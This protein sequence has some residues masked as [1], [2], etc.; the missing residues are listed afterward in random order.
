MFQQPQDQGEAPRSRN[1]KTSADLFPDQCLHALCDSRW[2]LTAVLYLCEIPYAGGTFAKRFCQYVG[3]RHRVLDGKIDPDAT[4]RRHGVR[5]I[6]DAQQS[7]AI[8]PPQTIDS[9]SQELYPFPVTQFAHA[10]TQ[11]GR[12]LDNTRAELLNPFRL[13]FLCGSFRNSKTALP[14]VSAIEQYQRPSAIGVDKQIRI[15]GAFGQPHPQHIHRCANLFD[16]QTGT[17]P[18]RGV[19]TVCTNHQF[20]ADLHRTGW[21]VSANADDAAL[22]FDQPC[23][24]RLHFQMKRWIAA[25]LLGQEVQEFPL[26]H[27]RDEAALGPEV[28]HI[29]QN[30]LLAGDPCVGS[31]PL[32]MRTLEKLLQHAQLMHYLQS[33][34]MNGV[35][36]EIAQEVSVFLQNQDL[37]SGASQQ[38]P[39]HHSS[40]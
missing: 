19:A 40:R 16:R 28:G 26:W 37:D 36:A 38:I 15:R 4:H 7:G 21:S 29:A 8:P 6:S 2:K 32:L 20:R 39:Q 22:L 3:G 27:H 1:I 31:E 14:I 9:D 18:D 34:G 11:E 5:R 25:P 24:L 23:D 10:V 33:R 30:H 17:V 12:E 35:P 13:H